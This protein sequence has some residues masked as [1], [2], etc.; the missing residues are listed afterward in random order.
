MPLRI[1]WRVL[2]GASEDSKESKEK[3]SEAATVDTKQKA[4]EAPSEVPSEGSK[5]TTYT[6]GLCGASV[7]PPWPLWSHLEPCDSKGTVE[8]PTR[9]PKSRD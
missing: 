9:L 2:R 7:V 6:C 8:K 5:E 4:S 3:V 1:R